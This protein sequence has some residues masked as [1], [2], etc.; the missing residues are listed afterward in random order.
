MD[1]TSNVGASV[2][3]PW[4]DAISPSDPL[5]HHL[6]PSPSK[7]ESSTSSWFTS[8]LHI[9]LSVSA[10]LSIHLNSSLNQEMVA[11]AT[12]GACQGITLPVCV[13]VLG[14]WL[15]AWCWLWSWL[16]MPYSARGEKKRSPTQKL[17]PKAEG[18]IYQTDIKKTESL[19]HG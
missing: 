10:S 19:R 8:N 2:V 7:E 3:L 5:L 16:S 11:L 13:P 15:S 1:L 14:L 6:P 12:M 17:I 9:S 18:V 4:R